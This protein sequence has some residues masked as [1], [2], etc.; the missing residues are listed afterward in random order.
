MS[1]RLWYSGDRKNARVYRSEIEPEILGNE[2][3]TVVGWKYRVSRFVPVRSLSYP[4]YPASILRRPETDFVRHSSIHRDDRDLLEHR[5]SVHSIQK[6]IETAGT[7]TNIQPRISQLMGFLLCL[8]VAAASSASPLAGYNV[9]IRETSVSGISSG[10]YMAVQFAIAHSDIV[11]GIGVFAGGPYRCG[12]GGVGTAL[13]LCMQG[14]PD[15]RNAITETESAAAD[16]R[17]APLDNIRRQRIW[18]FSGYNDGVVRQSVMNSLYDYFLHFVPSTHIF[19]QNTL[20]AGHAM[21]TLVYGNECQLTGG[22]FINDCDYDG[23]GLMLQHIHGGLA[24]P[25]NDPG[26]TILPFDQT[27]YISGDN[28]RSG[29]AREG[30]LYVPKS[31]SEGEPCRVHIAFHG[32]RQYAGEVE[33]KFYRYAGY[34]R[35]ADNNRIII[36]YPQTQATHLSPLNPQ[37]CWDWWGYSG[38]DFAYRTGAQIKAVRSMLDQLATDYSAS[39]PES[40]DKPPVLSAIDSTAGSV[41]LVWSGGSQASGYHLYRAADADGL[42]RR[43]TDTP[44]TGSSYVDPGLSPDMTYHYRLRP[45]SSTGEALDSNTAT[46]VTRSAPPACDPYFSDNVTH[47]SKGRANLWFGLTFAKGSWDFMG[48]WNLFSETALYR[49]RDGFQV[50]VC[51]G[52]P[53]ATP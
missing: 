47:V 44:E 30:Y 5:I 34:N 7:A 48:L 3:R 46:I 38:A 52:A 23:A 41:S 37:G 24:P 39:A 18:L 28:D 25:V 26:G 13:G 8:L 21:I 9:D 45:V 4:C 31:C 40:I 16:A 32:C 17:I 33:D 42:F 36:L 43:I 27:A 35:W 14:R 19:Y 29:M 22:A 10:A 20:P 49:D 50:G 2:A 53:A 15:P 12:A 1:V 11:T 51:S 6:M